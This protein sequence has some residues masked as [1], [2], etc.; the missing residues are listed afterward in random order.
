MLYTKGMIELKI[1]DYIVLI[2]DDDKSKVCKWK[3]QI[4]KNGYACRQHWNSEKK[5][6]ERMYMH[7]YIMDT[8]KGF[9]TDHINRN[10]LDNQKNNL[11]IVTRS[12]NN[13]NSAPSKANTSGHKGV[14]FHKASKLWRAY[15]KKD[16]KQICL[17]YSKNKNDAIALRKKAEL[18]T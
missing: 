2:D 13:F 5:R 14:N 3:W 9:D 6:Y 8:P 16:G 18:D 1:K 7:R 10:K 15:I 17:G 11:R 12:E 4:S